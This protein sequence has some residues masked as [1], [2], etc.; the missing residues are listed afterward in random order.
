MGW[1]G[2][3]AR[4]PLK[5]NAAVVPAP[6]PNFQVQLSIPDVNCNV[7]IKLKTNLVVYT[8]IY[9]KFL[10]SANFVQKRQFEHLKFKC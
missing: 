9:N 3:E 2:L 6:M 5:V 10:S 4:S 1:T 8:G 7:S